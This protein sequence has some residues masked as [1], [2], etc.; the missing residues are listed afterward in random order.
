MGEEKTE[1]DSKPKDEESKE[2]EMKVDEAVDTKEKTDTE[3]KPVHNREKPF[4]CNQ[5]DHCA[6]QNSNPKMPIITVH[7]KEKPF[8]ATS[9]IPR[10]LFQCVHCLSKKRQ[11]IMRSAPKIGTPKIHKVI[12]H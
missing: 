12:K 5:C 1:E 11:F 6:S 8:S 9:I 4:Q 3:E 2:E 10:R 7:N